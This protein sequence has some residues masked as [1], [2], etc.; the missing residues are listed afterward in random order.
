MVQAISTIL[1]CGGMSLFCFWYG[2]ILIRGRHSEGAEALTR[3]YRHSP[4][5]NEIAA[6]GVMLIVFGVLF[7]LPVI[8]L[9]IPE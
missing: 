7:L 5:P 2:Y 1:V 6:Q 4:T 8:G 9:F 3:S